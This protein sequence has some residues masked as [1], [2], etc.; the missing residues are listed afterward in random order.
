LGP[1][2]SHGWNGKEDIPE[3]SRMNDED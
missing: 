2:P 3:C 1:E